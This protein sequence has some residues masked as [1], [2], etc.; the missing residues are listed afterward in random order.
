[1]VRSNNLMGKCRVK[2]KLVVP[3]R[4]RKEIQMLLQL[5]AVLGGAQELE[6]NKV[7]MKS[8]NDN[9]LTLKVLTYSLIAWGGVGLV[10]TTFFLAKSKLNLNFRHLS[11]IRSNRYLSSVI[12]CANTG[13]Y[14]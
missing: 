14:H 2:I 13:T 10:L 6:Q 3:E 5:Q 12:Y 1:M 8:G 4:R 7:S 11:W 9:D